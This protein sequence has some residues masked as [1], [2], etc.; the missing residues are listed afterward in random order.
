VASSQAVELALRGESPLKYFDSAPTV[1]ITAGGQTVGE[2]HP[3][4]DFTWRVTVPA[5]V[6]QRAGGAIAIEVDRLYLPGPAEGT[7]DPRK[8]GLRLFEVA[9]SPAVSPGRP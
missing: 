9:V 5:D 3:S 6:M 2:L 4:S 7:T 8:L 1:R